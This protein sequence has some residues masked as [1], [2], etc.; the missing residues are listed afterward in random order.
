MTGR[1]G[2]F[3]CVAGIAAALFAWPL[4]VAQRTQA[5]TAPV[6][7]IRAA[8]DEASLTLLHDG[9][10]PRV[11]LDE[12]KGAAADDLRLSSMV[13]L[14]KRSADVQAAL[15][16]FTAD[17]QD[18]RSAAYHKWLTPEQM[19][20]RFGVASEDLKQ[21]SGWLQGHGFQIDSVAHSGMLILFSGTH[22]Q[23]REAFHTSLH[24]FRD[25]A[26]A[27]HFA[28]VAEPSIPAALVPVVAGIASLN[29]F[30]VRPMHRIAGAA[31]RNGATGEW[32]VRPVGGAGVTPQTLGVTPEFSTTVGTTKFQAVGPYDFAA[33]YDVLP[34]WSA[35]IDGTGQTIAVLAESDINTKDVDTFR[36]SFGL[37]AKPVTMVYVG[38]NPGLVVGGLEEEADLDAQWSGAVA[39]NATIDV[40]VASSTATTSGLVLG[41]YQVIDN[42]LA[43]VLSVSFGECELGLGNAGNQLYS[44]IWQQ[45]AAEGITVAIA[46]GDAGSAGCDQGNAN[47]ARYGLTVNGLATT[48]YN[49]AVGGTDLYGTYT[50]QSTYWSSTNSATTMQSALGYVPEI[51]WNDSCGNPQYLLALHAH[52]VALNDTTNEA[53]CNDTSLSSS[54]YYV[55]GG[56]GG[57]ASNCTNSVYTNVYAFNCYSGYAK[58][59]WQAGV[60]GAPSSARTIP[61]VSLF[62]GDGLWGSAYVL[63]DSDSTPDGVCNYTSSTD[64]EYLA[65]GGTSF[66]TPAFAGIMALVNQK[67]GARQGNAGP[68]LYRLAAKQ[69]ATSVPANCDASVAQSTATC[70]FQDISTGTNAQ[71]CV[72]GS[73]N[74]SPVVSSD[75]YAVLPGYSAGAGYDGATGL[76]SL[77]VANL[78]NAW[79]SVAT[80]LTASNTVLT[81]SQSSFVYGTAATGTVKVTAASGTNV[82]TGD[83]STLTTGYANGP[84]T[85]VA[86]QVAVSILG[87][88]PGVH[89]VTAHYEGDSN[90]SASDSAAISITVTQDPTTLTLQP[91]KTALTGADTVTLSTTLSTTSVAANPT[92]SVT[93][94]DTTNGALLGSAVLQPSTDAFGH[95]IAIGGL[96]ISGHLLG[97]GNNAIVANYAGDTNYVASA[98]PAVMVSYT[99]AFTLSSSQPSLT[100]HPNS[101][102]SLNVAVTASSGTLKQD[103]FLACP[104]ALPKGLSCVFSPAILPAGAA[105][106]PS[107]FTLYASSAL[108]S[109]KTST[110]QRASV[111]PSRVWGPRMG[112]SLAGLLMLL[113]PLHRRRRG[114]SSFALLP[115]LLMVVWTASISGCSSGG[116]SAKATTITLK[117]S[118]AS[119]GMGS[120]VTFT[121]TVV[122]SS[123]AAVVSGPVTFYENGTALSTSNLNTSGQATFTTST[124]APGN[125]TLT[126]T[127]AASSAYL[128]ATSGPAS[129]DVTFS[130]SVQ[131]TA[132]DSSANSSTITIPV[133][134]Q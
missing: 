125:N 64:M 90:F 29:N 56:G 57:G 105:S 113:M 88:T 12:D 51:P 76:G 33:I 98:A 122:D 68:I 83:V 95:V 121:S 14:L 89:A 130:T 20:E 91:S 52:N 61:D 133:T 25:A 16:Q 65:A 23:L 82:P 119:V 123:G 58:P 104:Q 80:S 34:L 129:T 21:V 81:L 39:K 11:F 102:G 126:A 36:A 6:P 108:G 5:V 107:T 49:V 71:P 84:F 62:A 66:G 43:S 2:F 120:P 85:L 59:S 26:G 99:S 42:N 78:V 45:A 9:V 87:L 46:S 75:N 127:F 38:P 18:P 116:A 74:C 132:T 103:V 55:Q 94:T 70:L 101:S 77:N 54:V 92:G 100:L 69:F 37:P 17:Q 134:I 48:A 86:G 124:L 32:T 13:L 131:L 67:L 1:L 50:A 15:D 128:S 7:Q 106:S 79:G 4:A 72:G 22:A 47:A 31:H 35:G 109:V 63:C 8:I 93:F 24:V 114:A 73:R 111:V 28:N 112:V 10:P 41:A 40:V 44:A 19:G 117:V 118:A 97:S 115:V 27:E 30:P 96:N 3:R 53:L 110:G 60:V